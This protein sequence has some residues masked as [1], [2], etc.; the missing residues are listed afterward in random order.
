MAPITILVRVLNPLSHAYT[1]VDPLEYSPIVHLELTA[2]QTAS[3][4]AFCRPCGA[5]S[6]LLYFSAYYLKFL[7][8]K[9]LDLQFESATQLN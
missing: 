4:P 1:L 7:D 2:S 5:S 8:A 9:L 3:Y 6:L